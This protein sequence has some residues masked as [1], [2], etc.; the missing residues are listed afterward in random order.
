[1]DAGTVGV[2]VVGRYPTLARV[3]RVATTPLCKHAAATTPVC[4]CVAFLVRL[5]TQSQPSLLLNQ[6]GAHITFKT[7]KIR[8]S[9]DSERSGV[10]GN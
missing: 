6:A 10:V 7:N 3:S 2:G 9:S 1:M 8:I 5:H 4:P